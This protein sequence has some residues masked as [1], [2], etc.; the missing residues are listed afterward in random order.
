MEAECNLDVSKALLSKE[1][2]VKLTVLKEH[3]SLGTKGFA[4][5]RC[6]QSVRPFRYIYLKTRY[7]YCYFN[8][9]HRALENSY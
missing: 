3:G 4:R 5:R 1:N 2:S 7:G 6:E 8:K 9:A